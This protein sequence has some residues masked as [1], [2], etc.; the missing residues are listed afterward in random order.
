MRCIKSFHCDLSVLFASTRASSFHT[1]PPTPV[2]ARHEQERNE[3]KLPSVAAL[4][5]AAAAALAAALL[6][7]LLGAFLAAGL[8]LGIKDSD[9]I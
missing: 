9:M 1:M 2:C 4:E 8:A 7:A 5:L 6:G 3:I